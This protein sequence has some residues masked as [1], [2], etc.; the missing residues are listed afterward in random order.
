MCFYRAEKSILRVRSTF[1]RK[2]NRENSI[3]IL[4]IP[5]ISLTWS[6]FLL[7]FDCFPLQV[8][9]FAYT[10]EEF[11]SFCLNSKFRFGASSHM[12]VCVFINPLFSFNMKNKMLR[13]LLHQKLK[14]KFKRIAMLKALWKG[15]WKCRTTDKCDR[16]AISVSK[17][18][19]F[20]SFVWQL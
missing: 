19:I 1:E 2:K 12:L 15:F 18:Y 6:L 11:H 20:I 7:S 5:Q 9:R 10:V 3:N 14:G 16:F 17:T 8:N 4:E 13:I